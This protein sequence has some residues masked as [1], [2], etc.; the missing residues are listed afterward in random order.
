[1]LEIARVVH[2]PPFAV[3]DG[4]L[5]HAGHSYGARD[6]ETAARIAEAERS[7]AVRAAERLRASGFATPTVSVGSTPTVLHARHLDG[8]TEVRAG[9]YK[10]GDLMQAQIG[11]CAIDDLAVSVLATVTWPSASG[12]PFADRRGRIGIVEGS[13]LPRMRRETMALGSLCGRMARISRRN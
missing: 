9:V 1:L 13:Q 3:L 11:S 6:L 8:V 7:G 4:T 5:T 10:F 2:A 12:W